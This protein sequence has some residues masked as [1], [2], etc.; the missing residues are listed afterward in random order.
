[1]TR[2][3]AVSALAVANIVLGSLGLFCGGFCVIGGL[4]LAFADDALLEQA[5]QNHPTVGPDEAEVVREQRGLMGAVSAGIGAAVVL[6][7]AL[8]VVGGIGALRR[9]RWARFVT[10]AAAALCLLMGGAW[11]GLAAVQRNPVGL[12]VGA[13]PL[14]YGAAMLVAHLLPRVR[15]E[16]S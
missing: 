10:I 12:V 7:C 3:P 16:F 13:V 9:R 1:M 4:V 8:A 15:A 2:G 14:L 6:A 5:L 11:T